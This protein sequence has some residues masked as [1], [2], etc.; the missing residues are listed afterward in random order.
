[1]RSTFRPISNVHASVRLQLQKEN[2]AQCLKDCWIP[3]KL[4][5]D[6]LQALCR[7]QRLVCKQLHVSKNN[8]NEYVVE[9]L[10][11]YRKIKDREFFLVKWKGYTEAENT[12]EP[13]RN[14]KC[15]KILKQFR[16]DMRLA[17]LLAN[18]PLDSTS[19]DASSAFFVLQ[20]AKQRQK[21]RRWEDQLNQ[22]CKH[23]GRMFVLNEVDLDIPPKDFTYITDYKLGEG[24]KVSQTAVGCK[25]ADCVKE[26]TNGCC[27][28]ASEHRMAYNDSRQV[29]IRPGLPIYECNSFCSCG[30]ECGNRV[31]QRGI[32]YDLCIFKTAN[33][34]GWGVRTLQM[35][36]KNAFVMEYL[37]EIITS[38]EAERRGETY[39]KQ[40]ATYLFDLDYVDD[41]YTVDAARY[42]NISHFVNHSVYN[43]FIDNLDERLPRIAF[44]A[45]RAIKS[46]E[47][48]TFDY[49]MTIDPVVAESKRMDTN[50][51]LA[52]IQGTPTQRMR[53][54]CKCGVEKC[55]KF[56][57]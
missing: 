31:V 38:E 26:P 25:C 6:D 40:G 28:G 24:V 41:V 22:K 33:G 7:R 34:R 44:F 39:D 56:L 15:P 53:M 49:K 48:L 8:F 18:K 17:L 35:I 20:K 37:G 29:K 30:P 55:R 5:W 32:Q 52:E 1:M 54:E 43:V 4:S 21:L 23:K 16:L 27:A 2:M 19:L 45:I 46:G 11:N 9:Y 42:G 47:E 51:S 57:F 3:C 50:F 36:K 12:W 14:L 13:H 10:C